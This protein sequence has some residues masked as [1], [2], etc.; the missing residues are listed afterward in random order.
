[1]NNSTFIYSI[2]CPFSNMPKYIGKSN[3]PEWRLYT[4]LHNNRKTKLNCYIKSLKKQNY[5]PLI[6]IIDE[7]SIVE[8]EFWEQHYISLYKSWGF[9][10]KNMTFGGEGNKMTHLSEKHK[11]NIRKNSPFKGKKLPTRSYTHS[12]NISLSKTGKKINRIYTE[13]ERKRV[14]INNSM[15]K[16]KLVL[17]INQLGLIVNEFHSLNQAMEIS[18]N[19]T[20]GKHCKNGSKCRKG[21]YWKWKPKVLLINESDLLIS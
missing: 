7:V 6:E 5:L 19:T 12:M 13:Q 4:H 11:Q 17:Q 8:W 21:F 3:D 10:L 20:I 9:N 1:M 15:L 14:G 2:N 18:K 16:T